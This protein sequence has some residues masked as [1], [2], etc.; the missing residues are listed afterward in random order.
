M[1]RYTLD[2]SVPDVTSSRYDAPLTLTAPAAVTFRA[3]RGGLWSPP[4]QAPL[5]KLDPRRRIAVHSP[6][7]PQYTGGGDQ[8]LID[9]LVGGTDFRL[10]RW[11]GFEGVELVA[12]LDLGDVQPIRRIRT[13]FLHDQDSWIFLPEAVVYSVSDD[14]QTWREVG[15]VATDLDPH[16]ED[17][18][19]R[20]FTLDVPAGTSARHV[21]LATRSLLR[22]PPWHKGAG[23]PAHLFADEI[24]VE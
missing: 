1:I 11:Q 20:E 21:R 7:N 14:G 17:A 19:R 23:R 13:G 18:E 12:D 4:V 22:C 9:G 6:I 16:Q 5:R 8:A 3:E 24:V 15:A 10:G 2:G